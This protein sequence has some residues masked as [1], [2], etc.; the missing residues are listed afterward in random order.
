MDRSVASAEPQKKRY[1]WLYSLEATMEAPMFLLGL[2][3]L[4]LLIQ[5]FTSAG[6]SP[7]QDRLLIVPQAKVHFSKL[8]YCYCVS[9][10]SAAG[11]SCAAGT[12]YSPGQFCYFYYAHGAFFN[13]GAAFCH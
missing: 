1:R 6:L 12:E 11:I 9:G 2:V 3:W 8:D 5:E 13:L 4:W 10:A 7:L